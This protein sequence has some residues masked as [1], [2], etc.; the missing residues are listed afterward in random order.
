MQR[1]SRAYLW[2]IDRAADAI[3][4]FVAGLDLQTYE[5][6]EITHSAVERKFEIIGESLNQL[7]AS[8]PEFV[9]QRLRFPRVQAGL[10]VELCPIVCNVR[11]LA[12]ESRPN[13]ETIPMPL[14]VHQSSVAVFEVMLKAFSAIL[15]KAL[16]HAEAHKFDPTVYMTM[17][18]RPDMLPFG[19]Q[20]MIVCDNAKNVPSRL[21]G[22]QAPVFEDNETTLDQLK[23]RIQRTLDYLETLDAKAIE[24]GADREIV[25]PL[26]P[27]KMKMQGANYLLH[28]ALPN[29]YFHL[30]TAYDILRY[31]GVDIGKRDFLGAVPGIAPA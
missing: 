26:G 3:E 19:R 2:D 16:A 28:F 29:F 17:R 14:S 7:A 11:A 27:N 31:A 6:S 24:S 15:D 30:T 18:L 4:R 21:A 12:R 13:E 22:V 23:A 10:P 5:Q 20:V 1:D 25:I 9:Q 8:S